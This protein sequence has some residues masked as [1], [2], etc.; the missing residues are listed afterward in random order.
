MRKEGVM[1]KVLDKKR[2]EVHVSV[3][4]YLVCILA[5]LATGGAG[6]NGLLTGGKELQ[7]A[8]LHAGGRRNLCTSECLRR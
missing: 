6:G 5:R 2:M 3:C 4:G 7:K 8:L 1:A